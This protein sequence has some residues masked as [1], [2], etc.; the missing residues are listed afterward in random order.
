MNKGLFITVEG[1]DG[2]G[3]TTQIQLIEKYLRDMG[4]EV[5]LV[6]EP[7]GTNI[8]EKIRPIILDPDSTEMCST[9]EMLLYAA[10]RAQLVA[11]VIKP[12][13]KAGKIVIC[14]RFVDSA[15][16]YQGYGRGIE[17]DI[18]EIVNKAAIDGIIPDITFFFDI[19]PEVALD[20]RIASSSTDRIENENSRFHKRVYEGYLQLAD[21][22]HQRIRR[23]DASRP[24][25]KVWE[26]VRLLLDMLVKH[27]K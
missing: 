20:R 27:G 11:E 22:S 18:L 19:S 7:G 15:Y 24:V 3:K 26:D 17:M 13:L 21:K 8:S 23:I 4:R 6:R 10:S 5:I 16:A 12:S 1:T 25:E 9:T 2:S 14:D